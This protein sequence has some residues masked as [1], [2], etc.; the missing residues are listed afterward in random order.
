VLSYPGEPYSE[1]FGG[2]MV[3]P[4][5]ATLFM[6]ALGDYGLLLFRTNGAALEKVGGYYKRYGTHWT[7]EDELQEGNY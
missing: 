3:R 7:T 1:H 6:A 2:S 4:F 5:G